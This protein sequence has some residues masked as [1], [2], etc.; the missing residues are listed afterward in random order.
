MGPKRL[1]TRQT[2]FQHIQNSSPEE[3]NRIYGV[4]SKSGRIEV[5]RQE[6]KTKSICCAF[7]DE[8]EQWMHYYDFTE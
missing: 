3:L 7:S 1:E 4:I 8:I 2:T 5:P 6:I